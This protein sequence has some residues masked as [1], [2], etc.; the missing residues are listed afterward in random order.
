MRVAYLLESTELCGGVKV[1]AQQAEALARRGH[2]VA[3]VSPRPAEKWLELGRART[4]LSSF[5]ESR[6]L[7]SADLR[8][9][10]FWTT[11]EPAVQGARGPV[12]HL[13]QG[14]EGDLDF[15]APVRSRI[16][17]A[18]S[19]PTHKLA[20]TETLAEKLRRKGFE[21]VTFVGQVFDGSLFHPGEVRSRAFPTV[22]LV[23]Q[24]EGIVKGIDVALEGLRIWRLR[25][26]QFRLRRISTEPPAPAE[27]E[28]DLIAEYHRSLDPSRMPFAY[29]D[30]DLFI[31][32]SRPEEGFGLPVLE[33]LAS[34][35]P[36]L[37]SDTPTH[38]E[39]AGEAAWYF[40]DGDPDALAAALPGLIGEKA[41]ARARIEGPR[42]AS[43]FDSASVAQKLEEVF[44]RALADAQAI[45][46]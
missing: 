24:Y 39:I 21:P 22:L 31:G 29:Q 45:R 33:A 16:E 28:D 36:T 23:G 9:A 3:I 1:V 46:S 27:T 37:L 20:I 6:E 25:G 34:G 11:A 32:P 5:S 7:S 41:R 30:A 17:A 8:I 43:R 12:F 4:E 26:G 38:R 2:S 40:A 18:Y 35:V 42:A 44:S 14:Y 15:Y 19:L 10:T 13:C